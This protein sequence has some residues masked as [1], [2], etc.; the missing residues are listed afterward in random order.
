MQ[1]TVILKYAYKRKKL[2]RTYNLI[3]NQIINTQSILI[4]C[5]FHVHKSAYSLKFSCNPKIMTCGALW[6]LANRHRAVKNLGHR[7]AHPAEARQSD[8]LLSCFSSHI[9]DKCPVWS[10]FSAL[11]GFF[12]FCIFLLFIGNFAI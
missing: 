3:D 11:W 7:Q 1:K 4:I 8:S 2:Q 5:R 6:S 10:L 9:V 12:F